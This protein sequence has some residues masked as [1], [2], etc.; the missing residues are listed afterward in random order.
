M[1]IVLN[2]VKPIDVRQINLSLDGN[3]VRFLWKTLKQLPDNTLVQDLLL[4]AI[5]F[6]AAD[7]QVARSGT[8]DQW[9]RSLVFEVPVQNLATWV[10]NTAALNRLLSFLTGDAVNISFTAIQLNQSKASP[11]QRRVCLLSGGLDSA[12]GAIDLLTDNTNKYA[13][14]FLGHYD[15][16]VSGPRK[17]QKAVFAILKAK[18]PNIEQH[19][20]RCGLTK[21][22]AETSFRSRSFLF[23]CAGLFLAN[24][25]DAP[26]FI[27]ENG[28]IAL[29]YPQIGRAHV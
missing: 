20:F 15:P 28:A 4:I 3:N 29:N 21:K 18:F 17:D 22:G 13:Y 10:A 7:K 26:L 6:Y 27:P 11:K 16:H 9:E 5:S 19:I 1:N 12:I 8:S 2:P 23:L 25:S 14:S 24:N